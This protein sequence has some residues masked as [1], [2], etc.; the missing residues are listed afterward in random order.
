MHIIHVAQCTHCKQTHYWSM[1]FTLKSW[2]Y[3]IDIFVSKQ[4]FNHRIELCNTMKH[5]FYHSFNF[6]KVLK[7]EKHTKLML[8]EE[9]FQLSWL[10]ANSFVASDHTTWL[11]ILVEFPKKYSMQSESDIRTRTIHYLAIPTSHEP[12]D[13]VKHLLVLYPKTSS[14]RTRTYTKVHAF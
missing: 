5:A 3:F 11:I 14:R 9:T 2:H 4:M 1:C 7:K 12:Y 8:E 6:K 13:L 10:K